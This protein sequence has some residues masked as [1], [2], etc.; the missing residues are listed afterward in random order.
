ME[1][2]GCRNNTPFLASLGGAIFRVLSYIPACIVSL[3]SIVVATFAAEMLFAVVRIAE[4]V[5]VRKYE[6][7]A[8]VD[9]ARLL[10][11]CT[12]RTVILDEI[13]ALAPLRHERP[14][15][16]LANIAV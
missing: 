16:F 13:V 15:F 6:R 1:H 3:V 5:W 7:A 8:E 2:R 11:L 9:R 4:A 12:L 10:R 14:V